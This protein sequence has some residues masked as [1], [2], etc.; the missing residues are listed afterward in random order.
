MPS[1]HGGGSGGSGGGGGRSFSS[2]GG[3]GR[4]GGPQFST[5]KP[6]SGG[7]RYDYVDRRGVPRFFYFS[8]VP[9]PGG[10]RNTV[11]ILSFAV[12]VIFIFFVFLISSLVPK[13]LNSRQCIAAGV[14]YEDT[15]G[16]IADAES[17]NSVMKAFY[18]KTGSEPFV[19][20]LGKEEFPSSVYGSLNKYTLE[21]FAYDEYLNRFDDEGH[22]MV[23]LVLSANGEYMWLDMAGDD[24]GKIVTDE[25]FSEFQRDMQ[26][27]FS[28]GAENA[29]AALERSFENMTERVMKLDSGNVKELLFI[30]GFFLLFEGILVA[31]LLQ[32]IKQMKVINDYC[33]YRADKDREDGGFRGGNGGGPTDDIFKS[34]N[35]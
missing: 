34:G 12:A 9:V 7:T 14:Y 3:S 2:G 28:G 17:F 35:F 30:S 23:V 15:Q 8:G 31:A 16:A 10:T 19:Y 18:E 25:I 20:V 24:T 29:G 26:R 22:Y 32:S 13:K 33:D 27:Y 4:G 6:F 11:V 21:D 1:S 5:N